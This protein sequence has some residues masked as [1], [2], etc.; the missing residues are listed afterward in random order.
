MVVVIKRN[1]HATSRIL[2][3]FLSLSFSLFSKKKKMLATSKTNNNNKKSPVAL[4]ALNTH[5]PSFFFL[6]F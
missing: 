5:I 1:T 2:R 6:P 3:A 4:A